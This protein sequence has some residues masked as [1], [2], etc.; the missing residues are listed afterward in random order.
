M[1]VSMVTLLLSVLV[2]SWT[3]VETFSRL[4]QQAMGSTEAAGAAA[5]VVAA[6]GGGDDTEMTEEEV[7][8][9]H[10]ALFDAKL[11]VVLTFEPRDAL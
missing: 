8:L 3:A 9:Q 5:P 10:F 2:A 6:E 1:P 4:L 7:G 11:A